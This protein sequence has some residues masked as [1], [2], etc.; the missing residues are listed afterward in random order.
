MKI[1]D[2]SQPLYDHMPVFPGDPEVVISEIHHLNKEGWS[3]RS[4]ALTTHIGTHV[5]VPSHMVLDGKSLDAYTIDQFIGQTDIYR[6]GMTMKRNKGVLFRSCTIDASIAQQIIAERPKFVALSERFELDI[7]LEKE[8]LTA[9]II[10]FEN[11]SH[12]DEL[13][14]A[15]MFYGVPLSIRASDGSPV[16]AFAVV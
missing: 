1:I 9:G 11:M 14:P 6:K 13:P 12:T 2:L 16:R 10:S 8:L 3:L 15:F 4:L 7:A 5:N